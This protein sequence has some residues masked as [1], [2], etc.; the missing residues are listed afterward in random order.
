MFD[1]YLPSQNFGTCICVHVCIRH[2][3][4]YVHSCITYNPLHQTIFN[5]RTHWISKH[6]SATA[7]ASPLVIGL[8]LLRELLQFPKAKHTFQT[9]VWTF[10]HKPQQIINI[11]RTTINTTMHTL[12]TTIWTQ[13]AFSCILF[14]CCRIIV[15]YVVGLRKYIHRAPYLYMLCIHSTNGGYR[16]HIM[17][18]P[19]YAMYCTSRGNRSYFT[20]QN[21]ECIRNTQQNYSI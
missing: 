11:H 14:L 12:L 1:Y 21:T 3:S 2:G 19:L 18:I 4:L 20:M 17:S 13:T 10:V 16:L 5:S 7:P 9:R 6:V 8:S 15:L